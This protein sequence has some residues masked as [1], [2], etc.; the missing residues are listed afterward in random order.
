MATLKTISSGSIGNCYILECND[1][2][3]IIEL[4]VS[5]VE[6]L[7]GVNYDLSKVRGCLS[8]HRH[9]DHSA[10]IEHAIRMGLSVYSCEDV[11]SVHQ[12]AKVLK[13]GLK[14]RIGG[15]RVQRVDLQHNVD[16]IG[17][18]IEHDEIGRLVFCTDTCRIPYIFKNVNHF[19]VEANYSNEIIVD[20]LCDNSY[21]RSASEN[22]MEITDT[23]EFLMRNYSS[24]CN[25]IVLIH[26]SQGNAD[27]KR[28]TQ[29][30][31]DELGF[32]NVHV[33]RK[34]VEVEL[35]KEEF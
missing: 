35:L 1:E 27:P 20:M 3:L 13:K 29:M 26:L 15:F 5:W 16:C 6:I 17:F 28:F 10:S 18:L 23:I 22:H 31:K 24:D 2:S 30:V 32:S 21:I 25:T 8:S 12:D 11:Q 14:T 7:K 34:G 4:G 19:V 33:A 9:L